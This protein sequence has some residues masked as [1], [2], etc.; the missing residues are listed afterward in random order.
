MQQMDLK[1]RFELYSIA[2]EEDL[3]NIAHLSDM[4]L[5]L[6]EKINIIT[7]ESREKTI[8]MERLEEAQLWVIKAMERIFEYDY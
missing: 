8:A 2:E 1:R 7:P 5:K 4:F 3:K 6:A